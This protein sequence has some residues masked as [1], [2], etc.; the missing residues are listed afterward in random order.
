MTDSKQYFST[1]APKWDE[2]RAG[3]FTAAMRD[4]AI[5]RAGLPP[6]AV[7]A[8][9]GTGTGFVLQGLLPHASRLVGFDASAEMLAVARANLA[10][11][12]HVE[13]RQAEGEALPAD[14]GA[15]DAVFANMYLH[16]APDPAHAIDEMVRILKP[17]GRL[18]VTD[19]DAHDQQWMR[20]EMADHWLGFPREDVRHWFHAAGLQNVTVDNAAG[21]CTS[22]SP[23]DETVALSVFL[24]V[25]TKRTS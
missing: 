9:V 4:D 22:R 21:A 5:A 18:V 10:S 19:L 17:G 13:L 20:S 7:V 6:S 3:Y 23:S 16:H 1:I 11:H 25:G 12:A 2:L 14:T 8:D 15:F 24:A